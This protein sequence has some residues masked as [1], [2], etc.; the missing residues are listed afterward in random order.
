M[1]LT[2]NFGTGKSE[3]VFTFRGPN[4]NKA[5]IKIEKSG[6]IPI[7]A[8]NGTTLELAFNNEHRHVGSKFVTGNILKP[9]IKT[10]IAKINIREAQFVLR[11]LRHPDCPNELKYNMA[12]AFVL[13]KGLFGAG[14]WPNLKDPEASLVHCKV[15]KVYRSFTR[16]WIR[17]TGH[18]DE[19]ALALY[20]SPAPPNS[21]RPNGSP[22]SAE[23]W[24]TVQSS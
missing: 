22:F 3:A 5:R 14:V 15:M 20:G 11:N 6:Y 18:D 17:E 21:Y 23:S 19:T 1:G 9:E 7:Q 12:R 13:S 8:R 16:D 24:R 4:K 2:I 10:K